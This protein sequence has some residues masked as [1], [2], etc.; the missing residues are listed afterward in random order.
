V[1]KAHRNLVAAIHPD[2]N[3][4]ATAAATIAV[5]TQVSFSCDKRAIATFTVVVVF[6]G[7]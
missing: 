3:D 2:H 7:S 5:L 6:Q 4:D 1:K